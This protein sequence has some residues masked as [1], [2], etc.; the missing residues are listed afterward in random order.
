MIPSRKH[1]ICTAALLAATPVMGYLGSFE[2]QDG[3]QPGG[4]LPVLDV[5]T[6][7]AG[8][9]GLSNFGPGGSLV[10]ITPN[11]GLFE[12][13]D[14]GDISQ[15][16][17]E[18]IAHHGTGK[19]GSSYLDLRAKAEF[20]DT[21]DDGANYLYTFDSRDFNG[22]LPAIVNAGVVTLDYWVSPQTALFAG[23]QVTTTEFVNA[24]GDTVFALGTVGQA[25][26]TSRPL[27]QW[28]DATGW[29]TSTVEGSNQ[30]SLG[31]WDH[32]MLSFDL[33][34]DL[35]SLTYMAS[36]TGITHTLATNVQTITSLDTLTGIRFTAA[37]GTEENAYDDFT[38][39]SPI[40]VPEPTT[41]LLVLLGLAKAGLSRRRRA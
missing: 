14:V 4:S 21:A 40:V 10:N 22:V 31:L 32:V 41:V 33:T 3:Y 29:H 34:N 24:A 38:I 28:W 19:T 11:T 37:P 30:G 5:S 1:L 25:S 17:G 9:Y 8:Q 39:V 7:N 23:G 27:I 16:T 18:L 12:K 26:F 13:F 6:Y 36:L 20:G 35:V 2:E 15:G